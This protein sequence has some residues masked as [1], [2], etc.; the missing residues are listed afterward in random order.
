MSVYPAL[1]GRITTLLGELQSVVNRIA[2]LSQKAQQTHDDGYW[3]GVALN[4]HSFYSGI[5][6]IFEDIARTVDDS[7]PSGPGWHANLI[8]Q[9]TSG[10]ASV[11]PAV[12]RPE[13]RACL[14][15]YRGFRH[16]VRNVYAFN[17][18]PAR[19][20]ELS[21]GLPPCWKAICEDLQQ[22]T[23]FLGAV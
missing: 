21:D 2:L 10:I 12:I 8:L 3:D 15:E 1:S 7:V 5:E 18:R 6:R 9:M 19:I 13:A 14:D 17:L 22:F 16:V 20:K 11:R 23:D 4:L